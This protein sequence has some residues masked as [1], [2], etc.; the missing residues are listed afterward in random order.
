MLPEGQ[1]L[2]H[3]FRAGSGW[4]PGDAAVSAPG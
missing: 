1:R 3:G 4:Q 2:L